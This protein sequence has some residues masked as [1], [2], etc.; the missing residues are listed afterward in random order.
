VL[1]ISAQVYNLIEDYERLAGAVAEEL[2]RE[3]A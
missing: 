2:G 1:R 3:R